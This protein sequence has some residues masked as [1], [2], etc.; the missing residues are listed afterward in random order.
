M[1]KSL[2]LPQ[3]AVC[4]SPAYQKGKVSSNTAKLWAVIPE[5]IGIVRGSIGILERQWSC[6][7]AQP[8]E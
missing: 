6:A 5:I 1:K 3:S 7:S 2:L 4:A 8:L